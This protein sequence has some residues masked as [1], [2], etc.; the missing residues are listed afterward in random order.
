MGCG[1]SRAAAAAAA[2]AEARYLIEQR[3]FMEAVDPVLK[4]IRL[5]NEHVGAL[6]DKVDFNGNGT[7][8]GP[9]IAMILVDIGRPLSR[10][11]IQALMEQIDA[12][13]SGVVG[14]SEFIEWYKESLKNNWKNLPAP[15]ATEHRKLPLHERVFTQVPIFSAA[16]SDSA[17]RHGAFFAELAK[18][19][20][21][22]AFAPNEMFIRKGDVGDEVYFLLIV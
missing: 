9:E 2:A 21:A 11:Q 6:W 19:I 16:F 8:E 15:A 12:D 1:A 13:G 14:K 18:Y 22:R 5:A 4:Q 3:D 10:V 7:L 20:E 17:P